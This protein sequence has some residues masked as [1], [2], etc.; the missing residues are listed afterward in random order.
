MLLTG[1][2]SVEQKGEKKKRRE[3]C[4]LTGRKDRG[5]TVYHDVVPYSTLFGSLFEYFI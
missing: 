4:G 3:R 2:G 5:A 1:S